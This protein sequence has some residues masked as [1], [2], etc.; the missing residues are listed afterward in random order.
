[1]TVIDGARLW[2]LHATHGFPL[3]FSVPMAGDHDAVPD[4]LGLLRAARKDGANIPALI[5]R[6]DAVVGDAYAPP[7][8]EAIRERLSLLPAYLA[9]H[10]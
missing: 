5:R 6:L 10:P 3:E 2:A 8:A 7:I 9:A 4:W 1:M